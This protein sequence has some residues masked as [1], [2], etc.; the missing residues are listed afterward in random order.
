MRATWIFTL[1]RGVVPQDGRLGTDRTVDDR[2][3][4]TVRHTGVRG[5]R[6]VIVRA[7]RG[8]SLVTVLHSLRIILRDAVAITRRIGAK[9]CEPR[10][11][12]SPP[13]QIL[14]GSALSY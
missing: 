5:T 12:R 4:S 13:L 2:P 3:P 7:T 9:V 11:L 10:V 14:M 1:R 8:V 6:G